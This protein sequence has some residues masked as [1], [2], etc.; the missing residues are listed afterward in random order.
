MASLFLH[1]IIT[2][3]VLLY[4]TV[5][6]F[7]SHVTLESSNNPLTP[8]VPLHT[9]IMMFIVMTLGYIK[10]FFAMVIETSMK[11][12]QPHFIFFV[13]VVKRR[14]WA[15]DFKGLVNISSG[16]SVCIFYNLHYIC[17]HNA[18]ITKTAPS[19]HMA[20][21]SNKTYVVILLIF[22]CTGGRFCIILVSQADAK[23]YSVFR[24]KIE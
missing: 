17:C 3:L 6:I 14:E 21:H 16:E 9:F 23:C 7:L 20:R 5:F 10:R 4:T 13:P 18:K 22:K 11:L 15:I 12:H 1:D 2:F 24:T 19:C 8:G